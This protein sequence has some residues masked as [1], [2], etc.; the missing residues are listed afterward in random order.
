MPL[1]IIFLDISGN[2][3]KV[4]IVKVGLWPISNIIRH[5]FK[6]SGN[7]KVVC[8]VQNFYRQYVTSTVHTVWVW[9][10]S[11]F[12]KSL[13]DFKKKALSWKKQVINQH[14]NFG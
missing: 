2:V 14:L 11:K 12:I 7:H 10:F 3:R 1:S 13:T 5:R 9:A 6:N 4:V 8:K